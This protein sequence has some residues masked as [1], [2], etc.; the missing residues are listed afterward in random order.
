MAS[1]SPYGRNCKR[2]QFIDS[3]NQRQTILL[4]RAT[5]KQALAIKVEVEQLEQAKRFGHP[6]EAEV[7]QW[8]NGLDDELYGRIADAGLAPHRQSN[9]VRAFLE[10]YLQ[11]RR[12]ELK[13]KSLK[14]LSDTRDKLLSPHRPPTLWR[15]HDS[16]RDITAAQAT[17]W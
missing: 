12:V 2:V 1:I 5:E 7:Q 10:S 9:Q 14:K 6:P 15:D 11:A 8:L 17:D 16:L 3:R 4:G 13:P